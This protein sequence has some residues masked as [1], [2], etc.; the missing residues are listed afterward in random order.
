PM[1]TAIENVGL[2]NA[3][4]SGVTGALGSFAP[5]IIMAGLFLLTSIFTQVLSNTA[6]A[7][8]I[9][10]VA[11]TM[12][13]Q[14]GIEPYSFLMTVARAASPV[15]S[16]VNTLVMGAGSYRFSDYLKI[17][18]PLLFIGLVLAMLVLPVLFPFN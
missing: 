5:Q 13:Q 4:A 1:A 10:P 3:V 9:A 18:L 11:I 2:V 14:L 12:A 6:T 8:L 15:A 16:P 17:G 7:V